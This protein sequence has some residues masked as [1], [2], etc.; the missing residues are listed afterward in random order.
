MQNLQEWINALFNCHDDINV[1]LIYLDADGKEL[2]SVRYKQLNDIPC[3]IIDKSYRIQ[4]YTVNYSKIMPHNEVSE[5]VVYLIRNYVSTTTLED[6]INLLPFGRIIEVETKYSHF[7]KI[8][9]PVYL[10][11]DTFDKVDCAITFDNRY[12]G[13]ICGDDEQVKQFNSYGKN[14]VKTII[15]LSGALHVL[16][17]SFKNQ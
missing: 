12:G 10:Y 13:G 1:K 7:R 6:F 15:P 9:I 11:V 3:S 17:Q 4:S 2:T 14:Y 16:I 8:N 5:V